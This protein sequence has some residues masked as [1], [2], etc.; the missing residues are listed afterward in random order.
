MSAEPTLIACFWTIGGRYVFGDDDH[1]PWDFRLRAEAAARAGYRGIGIK[2]ADLKRTLAHYGHAGIRSILA[3]NELHALE[4]EALFDWHQSGERREKSDIVRSELLDS[5]AKLGAHHIK[6]AGDFMPGASRD[7]DQMHDEFQVLARQARE[8]GTRFTLEPIAFSNVPS[9][10]AALQVVGESAGHGG[11]VMLDTWHV[12]RM[13]T[14]LSEI[15]AL[16]RGAIGGAEL[17]DGTAEPVGDPFSDTL[18][19][20]RLCGEGEFDL[21]GFIAAVRAAGYEGPWGVEIISEDQRAR[22]LDEAAS[23][24]FATARA[25]F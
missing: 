25:Q 15:A 21:R 17:D 12:A 4:L 13:R 23:R 19:R 7:L 18:D 14:P 20:R 9:L 24:S 2:H 11:G 3:D 5:A 8:A 16:P 10:A 1:S 22:P 6:A